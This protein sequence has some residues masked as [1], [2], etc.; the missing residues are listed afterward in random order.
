MKISLAWLREWV[1]VPEPTALAAAMTAAGIEVEE[2]IDPRDRIASVVVAEVL[3]VEPHPEADKLSLCEVGLG[4]KERFSVVCGAANVRVGIRVPYAKVGARLGE[5]KIS[6]RKLR[7][8]E[9]FGMLCSQAE[10]G[11]GTDDEGLWE[12][13]EDV[14]LGEDILA[15][16]KASAVFDLAITANRGDLLSHLGVARE[17][18]AVLGQRLNSQNKPSKLSETGPNIST[19]ARLRVEW[20]E[21]CPRYSGRLIQGVEIGPSPWWLQRRLSDLGLRSINNVVDVTNLVLHELGQPL[22]AF[23]YDK[24]RTNEGAAELVVRRAKPGE[25]LTTL[26]GVERSLS[27][28]DLVIANA[29]EAVALAGVMGGANSEVDAQTQNIFLESAHF[30]PAVVRRGAK[31]AGLHTDASHRFERGID[32]AMVGPALERATALIV[33]LADGTVAK[34]QAVFAV[35]GREE[36]EISIRLPR[37]AKLLGHSFAPQEVV[38]LLEP[39]EL[40]CLSRHEEELRFAIPS[41][42]NDLRREVDVIEEVARRFGYDEIQETLPSTAMPYRAARP[43]LPFSW[44]VREAMV[45]AGGEECVTYGFGSPAHQGEEG[46]EIRNPLGEEYSVLRTSLLPGLLTVAAYNQRQ[47]AASGK[48]FEIGNTVHPGSDPLLASNDSRDTLLPTERLRV[49]AVLY[50][51]RGDGRWSSKGET[52]DA[53][54]LIGWVEQLG[55]ALSPG[56]PLERADRPDDPR[57]NPH[58]SALLTCDGRALGVFGA[59]QPAY[60]TGFEVQ[61]PLFAF[62]FDLGLWQSLP[63]RVARYRPLGRFPSAR[64]D[65]ALVMP[66][67]QSLQGV[68]AALREGAEGVLPGCVESLSVFDIYRGKGI[69][70]GQRSVAF[71][72]VLRHAART[73]AE[74]EIAAAF[75][76]AIGLAQSRFNLQLRS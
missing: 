19:L 55:A 53:A 9:S 67:T 27:E 71:A 70:Q 39:L 41:F 40:R 57:F 3:H 23:D 34:D 12:L 51:E 8:V 52:V 20:P 74:E 76:A 21:A 49:A 18:A 42:R 46:L 54:D 66:E 44:T 1:D 22:H 56:T 47:G 43:A 2:L 32:D 16:A 64:R 36:I 68:Q 4:G 60:L 29:T 17:V 72:L 45:A 6:K 73:L 38:K 26:D 63:T 75:D 33:E 58:A 5:L 35:A 10:L 30:A 69:P 62:E 25:A 50:G 48:L 31:R 65:V 14:P 13:P 7:G 15:V 61:G 28:D 59:L 24:L 11:L 37:V